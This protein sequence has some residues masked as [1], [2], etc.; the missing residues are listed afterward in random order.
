MT[1]TKKTLIDILKSIDQGVEELQKQLSNLTSEVTYLKLENESLKRNNQ[2]TLSQIKEYI[3]E[4]E[5]IRNHYV[6]N[7]HSVRK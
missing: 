1:T 2:I 3:Q 4:L 7:N 6:D 5:Q